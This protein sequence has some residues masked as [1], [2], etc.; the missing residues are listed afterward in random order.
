MQ[1]SRGGTGD[2]LTR[3]GIITVI[4]LSEVEHREELEKGTLKLRFAERIDAARRY[5]GALA[6]QMQRYFDDTLV[7]LGLEIVAERKLSHAIGANLGFPSDW[8][9]P[10]PTMTSVLLE[11]AD[12]PSE[13][14][15]YPSAETAATPDGEKTDVE[16][17]VPYRQRLSAA[18]FQDVQRVMRQWANAIQRYPSAFTGLSEDRVSDL[19]AATLNATLPGAQRE[20]YTRSGKSDIFIQATSWPRARVLPR[21]LSANLSG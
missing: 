20:V 8:K 5:V 19:L 15:A 9:A 17:A 11:P 2:G 12:A 10:P 16:H 6:E 21:S 14:G 7:D 1:W 18:S 3:S 13:P 4:E